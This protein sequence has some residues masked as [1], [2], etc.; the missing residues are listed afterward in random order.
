VAPSQEP[1][2]H[3]DNA[4]FQAP[5]PTADHQHSGKY[6]R[7]CGGAPAAPQDAQRSP[8][9]QVFKRRALKRVHIVCCRIDFQEWQ[10]TG[11]PCLEP[12]PAAAAATD[13]QQYRAGHYSVRLD[14]VEMTSLLWM[15]WVAG[16]AGECMHAHAAPVLLGSGL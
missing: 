7:V 10:A 15:F 1:R 9:S 5:A 13:E 14:D 3:V 8:D 12:L 11:G 16:S 4:R 6:V 2:H